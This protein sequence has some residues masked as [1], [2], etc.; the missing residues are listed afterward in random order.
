MWCTNKQIWS[1]TQTYPTICTDHKLH[2]NNE[3]FSQ[4]S[5]NGYAISN[6]GWY[7]KHLNDGKFTEAY[8]CHLASSSHKELKSNHDIIRNTITN[9]PVPT[10]Q[11]LLWL[12]RS[13]NSYIFSIDIQWYLM[14]WV[15]YGFYRNKNMDVMKNC[16]YQCTSHKAY[17]QMI[18]SIHDW[19]KSMPNLLHGIG[20]AIIMIHGIYHKFQRQVWL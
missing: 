10:L 16:V 15:V 19:F 6:R 18:R 2:N 7:N 11:T 8:M 12:L 4:F 13:L 14:I 1:S 5:R 9:R 17:N 3:N 20:I